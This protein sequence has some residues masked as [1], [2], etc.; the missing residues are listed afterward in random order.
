MWGDR[1][2]TVVEIDIDTCTR[3]WGVAP[4]TAS[5]GGAVTSKCYNTFPTCQAI[6]AFNKGVKTLR[7]CSPSFPIKTGNYIPALAGDVAGS[8]QE[9]NIAGYK[10]NIGSLG[11]RASVKVRIKDF[12]DRD[13]LTDPY[14]EQRMNGSAQSN[15]IGYNPMDRGTFWTKF[16]ARNPNYA[17]RP[18]RV[19]TGRVSDVGVFIPEVTRSYVMTEMIGPGRAG[20]VTINASDIL[21]LASDKMAQAPV[22]SRGRLREDITANQTTAVL[23]PAGIGNSEY[24][25]AG[26]ATV[27]SEIIWFNR[28][29]DNLTLIRARRGTSSS[30]HSANDSLQL[31]YHVDRTR[32][33]TVI[34]R[35]LT[36]YA[37]VPASYI[38][39]TEWRAE[40]DRWG[41][42][43]ELSAT[44]C[45]PTGVATLIGE[46]N[47]LGITVWWDEVAQRIRIKLNHPP[48]ETPA[49]WS[50]RNNIIS[51][52]QEDNDDERATR[53]A[54]WHVQID[55]TKE[56]NKDNFLRGYINVFVDGEHARFYDESRTKTIYTR[57]LN[58]GSDSAAKIIT[59]RLL[60][61]Y[62]IAP[63]TYNVAV[64]MKDNPS[65]ADVVSL[66]SHVVTDI[67]GLEVP[68]LT[69]VFYRKDD[70]NGSTVNVKLQ[71]FQFDTRYGVITENTR[72]RYNASTQAQKNKGTYIVGPSLVFADGRPAYQLV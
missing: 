24:P 46:I 14:W 37:K 38:N 19:I 7:F 47:Q 18:L 11:V 15:G 54:F 68:V 53:V 67:N 65:L 1:I 34:Y 50:D 66:S 45:K 6:P 51:I 31:A 22:V 21:T 30:T 10:Q 33:D 72:P 59:G 43:L 52:E 32:A 5:F 13:T 71:R 56:L 9:I 57:W 40:F 62:K 12:T 2:A 44:I 58:H 48:E 64:D 16:K 23:S 29:G 70:R 28:T 36:Q 3:T 25:A 39:L 69:Q 55:P 41:S 4:C 35:L 20:E 61:R 8:E 49:A 42:S 60:N 27:G 17:G 26:Y 63:V